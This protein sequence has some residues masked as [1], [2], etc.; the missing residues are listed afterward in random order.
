MNLTAAAARLKPARQQT[1]VNKQISLTLLP[2][3]S[4][5]LLQRRTHHGGRGAAHGGGRRR[6]R[7]GRLRAVALG[8]LKRTQAG[9]VA[10]VLFERLRESVATGAVSNKI[11]FLGACRIGSRVERR[12]ARISN[13]PRRKAVDCIGVVGRYLLNLA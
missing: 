6:V 2:R 8:L 3:L 4:R 1:Q 12:A 13:R 9:D 7:W 5:W 10:L 11:E